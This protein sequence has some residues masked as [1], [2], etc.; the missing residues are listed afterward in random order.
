MSELPEITPELIA[1]M[2]PEQLAEMDSLIPPQPIWTPNPGPQTEGR[3]SKADILGLGGAAGGG[4]SYF[5]CGMASEHQRSAIFRQTG[6]ELTAIIDELAGLFGTRKGFN[7]Q[8]KVWSFT[9]YDG[10]PGQIKLGSFP[11]P[12]DEAKYQGN[13]SDLLVFEEAANMRES[14]VRFLMGWLRTP[15]PNQ[16]CRVVMTFNP[17]TTVEGFWIVRFFGPWLDKKHPNPAKPG[18][19]R[20]FAVNERGKDIEVDGPEPVTLDDGTVVEPMSR[21]F[22]PVKVKDNPFYAGR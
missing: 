17:P 11:H 18:E 5:S 19:L 14:A 4:K 9:R 16:R 6:T 22:I 3:K 20:W 15:D 8:T 10:V 21:T 7:G 13:P 1:R 12:G 2:T